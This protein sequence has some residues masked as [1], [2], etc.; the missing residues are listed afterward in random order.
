[1]QQ[2]EDV[3]EVAKRV[4][5]AEVRLDVLL[6]IEGEI[7]GQERIRFLNQL[8]EPVRKARVNGLGRSLIVW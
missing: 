2:P 5:L 8:L 4:R 7:E 3:I 1:M 6:L